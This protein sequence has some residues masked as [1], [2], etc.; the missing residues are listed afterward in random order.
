LT[1][2]ENQIMLAEEQL[3]QAMLVSDVEV[4]DQLLSS[5][6]VFTNH[7]GQLLTKQADL[8][9]HRSAVLRFNSLEPSEQL[10]KVDG[11]FS[12]VSV[13]M[14]LLGI[15]SGEPFTADLRYTRIWRKT[16]GDR[17]QVAAGHSSTIQGEPQNGA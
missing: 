4:L 3:R 16:E 7:L 13:R 10:L 12:I 14:K 8:E 9:M 15:Y 6:L 11:P 5:D 2:I 17:W 1:N